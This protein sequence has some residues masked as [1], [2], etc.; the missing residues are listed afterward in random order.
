MAESETK[1]DEQPQQQAPAQQL[2][3]QIPPLD[4][5]WARVP[6]ERPPKPVIGDEGFTLRMADAKSYGWAPD[7]WP[8]LNDTPR[9]SWPAED[10]GLP[11]P[12]TIYEKH[13]VWADNCADLYELA[14]KEQWKPATQISWGS[15][16]PL[17]ER[18][19][20]STPTSRSRRTTRTRR[21]PGA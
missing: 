20:R 17:P 19:T 13:E 3:F 4:M 16:E 15:I 9:G 18:S 10:M 7:H 8:Y 5:S 1:T 2:P 11:A 6:T 21:S 14:I 12:Y